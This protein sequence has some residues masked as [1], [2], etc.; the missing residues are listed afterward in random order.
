MVD[1]INHGARTKTLSQSTKAAAVTT[2]VA[3]G[4]FYFG[5]SAGS[6]LKDATIGAMMGGR[7]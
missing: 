1:I 7:Q 3:I 6:R 5:S 4:A 2:A